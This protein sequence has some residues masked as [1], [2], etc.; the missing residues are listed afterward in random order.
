MRLLS[1]TCP[2][3]Q[4]LDGSIFDFR[5]SGQS[6]TN[7]NCHKSNTSNDI[8][9]KLEPAIKLGKGNTTTSKKID[10]CFMSTNCDVIIISLINGH[11]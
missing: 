11:F 2:I 6:L 10:D 3:E 9:M 5:I 4:N 1:L 7:E 8:D